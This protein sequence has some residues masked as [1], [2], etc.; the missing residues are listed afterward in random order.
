MVPNG[1]TKGNGHKSEH[2]KFHLKVR[3]NFFTLKVADHWNK[4]P[5]EI[6]ESLLKIFKACLDTKL[7]F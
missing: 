2:R 4:L 3:K 7:A 6:V 5:R 1:K